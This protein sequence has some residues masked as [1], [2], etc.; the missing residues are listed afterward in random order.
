[1]SH[2][3]VKI[4]GGLKERIR[5]LLGGQNPTP[6]RVEALLDELEQTRAIVG[7]APTAEQ[8]KPPEPESDPAPPPTPPPVPQAVA[9][10]DFEDLELED[11]VTDPDEPERL[12]EPQDPRD[13]MMQRLMLQNN[14]MM[15]QIQNLGQVIE[16][17]KKP[18][19]AQ[20]IADARS[21]GRLPPVVSAPPLG[22]TSGEPGTWPI[23]EWFT[24]PLGPR[25]WMK[26]CACCGKGT[27][28]HWYCCIC[29]AGPF[30]Y[31]T[32]CKIHH[33]AMRHPFYT[34]NHFGPGQVWGVGHACCSKPCMDDYLAR[35]GVVAG[36]NEVEGAR[37]MPGPGEAQGEPQRPVTALTSD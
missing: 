32:P 11:V 23:G 22:F 35:M 17:M 10:G 1:M 16:Q 7:I 13:A 14:L 25:V 28:H 8:P 19:T 6:K 29:K 18:A 9:D 31:M 12:P 2:D 27:W 21:E 37:G 5:T 3:T 36:V 20:D 4:V 33:D 15:K 26:V 24:S 34:K 30:H